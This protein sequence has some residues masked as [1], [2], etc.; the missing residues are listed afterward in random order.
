MT[1]FL[2]ILFRHEEFNIYSNKYLQN[3]FDILSKTYDIIVFEE[4]S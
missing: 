3:L 1:I 4:I 2:Q